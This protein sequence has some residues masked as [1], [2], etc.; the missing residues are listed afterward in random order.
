MRCEDFVR[1]V[2]GAVPHGFIDEFG[3]G[4]LRSGLV[5][6]H[7]RIIIARASTGIMHAHG[8]AE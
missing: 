2:E 8:V 3:P 5:A 4:I 1:P 6:R 7:G